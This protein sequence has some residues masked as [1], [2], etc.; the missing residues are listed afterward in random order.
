MQNMDL[1]ITPCTSIAHLAGALARPTWVGLKY[2]PDWR[3]F[4]DRPD[5]P[6]YPG[7]RLFRQQTPGDWTPVFTGMRTALAEL[8]RTA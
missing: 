5:C 4:L 6:W 3:W 7:M 1:I 2:V 8:I